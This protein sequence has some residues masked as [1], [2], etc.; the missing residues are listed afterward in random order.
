MDRASARLCVQLEALLSSS[1]I[2]SLSER[3]AKQ[4]DATAAV[5]AFMC[6]V[7]ERMSMTGYPHPND[8]IAPR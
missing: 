4:C 5:G 2:L 8:I 1:S 3:H 7:C 6:W